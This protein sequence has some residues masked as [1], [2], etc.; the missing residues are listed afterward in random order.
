MVPDSQLSPN[1]Q[2]QT[3]MQQQLSPSQQRG[4]FSPQTNQ[5]EPFTLI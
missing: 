2:Q 4:P 5:G 1:F 3:L